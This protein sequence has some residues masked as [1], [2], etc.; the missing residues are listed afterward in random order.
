MKE[1]DTKLKF[2]SECKKAVVSRTGTIGWRVRCDCP[3]RLV[4][5]TKQAVIR[6]WNKFQEEK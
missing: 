3:Y 5:K 1:T 2:C 4:M 6:K